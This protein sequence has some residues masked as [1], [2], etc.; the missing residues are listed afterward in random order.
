MPTR[1]SNAKLQ[2]SKVNAHELGIHCRSHNPNP[3]HASIRLVVDHDDYTTRIMFRS[4]EFVRV[5]IDGQWFG[6]WI[7]R[8]DH[9]SLANEAIGWVPG[10]ESI[11]DGAV[12]L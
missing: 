6:F 4:G 9:G 7:D 3:W 10:T 2:S 12:A 5:S 8:H 11:L 1:S